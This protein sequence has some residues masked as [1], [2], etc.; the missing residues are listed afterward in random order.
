M[1]NKVYLND[2]VMCLNDSVMS[3]KQCR[4]RPDAT[5]VA[6]DLGLHSLFRPVCLK[7]LGKY[8]IS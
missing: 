2:S 3:D 4:P 6:S 5:N 7:T 1:L 8:G